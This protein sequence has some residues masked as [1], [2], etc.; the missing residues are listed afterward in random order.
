MIVADLD[1]GIWA[2]NPAFG[3][4]AQHPDQ[5][6]I[7]AKWNGICDVGVEEPI[8][9]NNKLIGARY[10]G[11]DFGNDISLDFNSP[12]DFNGHGSHTASTAAGNHGVE[13][14]ARGIAL[15]EMSGMAPAARIAAYKVLWENDEGTGL[16]HHRRHRGRHRRRGRRRRR[17]H[18]L[19]HLR[20]V[21]VHRDAGRGGVLQRR[22]R[23]RV[24]LDL[25]RQLRR[26][27]GHEQR[28]PQRTVD[29]D[30][31]RQ[32]PRPGCHQDGHPGRRRD[33]PGPRLRPGRAE[34][35]RSCCPT[36]R[37]S[38]APTPSRRTCA[39][40]PSGPATLSST[41]PRSRA[42]SS[43]ARAAPTTAW[44]RARPSWT[45]VASGMILADASAAT[46][47]TADF[48]SV[49]SIHVNS[50]DGAAVKA[51]VASAGAG[52][53]A[54]IS[55]VD[56][57]PVEAPSMARLLLVRPGPGRWRRPAQAGHHRSGRQRD[58]GRRASGQRRSRLQRL[59]RHVDGGPAH[60]G[61]RGPAPA[62]STRAGRRCG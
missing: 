15:G 18:Q 47:P 9:C 7:D 41:R 21:V 4:L 61:H 54:A 60:H 26:H 16:R 12:R 50:V 44:T 33:V 36:T 46:T 43:S 42:R 53:T 17:R 22:R 30:G 2:E 62:R 55:A 27:R 14:S 6:R 49:P 23:R 29:D 31:R 56:T 25:G 40:R 45:R 57:S 19:Q 34:Q 52:A 59:R 1:S 24:R 58:R 10:Y 13:A 8:A 38:P 37:R 20:L 48:H 32:H 11:E 35:R 3:P 51:Y 39:S 5:A 28:R